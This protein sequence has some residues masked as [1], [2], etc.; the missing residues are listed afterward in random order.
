M[1]RN[2]LVTAFRN[3][4]RIRLYAAI[5]I[6]GLAFGIALFVLAQLITSNERTFD[7]F[8]P[9]AERIYAVYGL[10]TPEADVGVRSSIGV[11]SRVAPLIESDVPEVEFVARAF[12]RQYLATHEDLKFYQNIRFVDPNFLDIFRFDFVQGDAATALNDPS[13]LIITSSMAEK[14]FGNEEA[15]GKV[16]RV[17]NKTDLH[18]TAVIKDLPANSHFSKSIIV[19]MPLQMLATTAA[20]EKVSDFKL[21]GNWYN[22]STSEVTYVLLKN[23]VAPEVVN[24]RLQ[25]LYEEHVPEANREYM[26]SFELRELTQLNLYPWEATGLP[27]I[28]SIDVLGLLILIIA[29][30]NYTNLSTAQLLGRTRE[31]GLRR[32]MGASRKQMFSQ[33]MTESIALAVLALA[34]ALLV[35]SVVI[36]FLNDLAGKN[37]E[38]GLLSQPVRIAWLALLAIGTGALAG[39]YPAWMISR[40]RTIGLLNGALAQGAKSG[41][42]RNAMLV[43]QFSIALF[44]MMCAGI[45][46]TQ[47]QMLESSS[48][49]FDRDRIVTLYRMSRDEIK[50]KVDTL[51]TEFERIPGIERFAM[52]N[53][54]PFEQEQSTGLFG[55][56]AAKAET[57]DM[58]RISIDEGFLETYDIPLLQG[59]NF[60]DEYTNDILVTDEERNPVQDSVNTIVNELALEQ[61][62]F[63]PSD[64]L[65]KTFYRYVTDGPTVEYRIVGV[66]ANANFLGFHNSLKPIVFVNRP[67]NQRIASLKLK[68]NSIQQTLEEIDR[69]WEEQVPAFPIERQFLDKHFNDVYKIFR[70]I[71]VA[72]AGFAG[73]AVLVA[74]IGLFGMAAFMAERRTREIGIR[75]V[76]GAGIVDI[77]RLLL[78]QFSRPVLIAIF[79]AAPLAWVTAGLYLNFFAERAAMPVGLFLEAGIAL[80]LLAWVTVINHALRVARSNPILALRYE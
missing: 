38:L 20:L 15:I 29:I 31:V 60:S 78:L 26:A 18:V 5:N 27:V 11:Q 3:L 75:K 13:G 39:C 37:L 4:S 56:T 2:Y 63:S 14:Y 19:D 80:L 67:D 61:L 17:K 64:A 66:I 10:F 43:A 72:L 51:R 70:G 6:S 62:G 47:N 76:L 9:N 58:Y 53:Q 8:F 69:V 59:R 48:H 12:T 45:I 71:N 32:V 21:E 41:F 57:I 22:M 7:H 68:G 77:V 30:F 65:D 40:G 28:T 55:H 44:M 33:F 52:S 36:P 35:L 73:M 23:N 42:I 34:I 50:E 25:T 24:S 79:I 54:V 46:Y 74:I 1:F 49:A 16:I